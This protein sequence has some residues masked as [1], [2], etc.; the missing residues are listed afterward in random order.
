MNDVSFGIYESEIHAIVGENG[1]G[2][3]TLMNILS[4]LLMA[5]SGTIAYDGAESVAINSPSDAKKLGIATV[6]QELK[7]C[8]ELTVAENI[9]L[10]NELR[11]RFGSIEW[12]KMRDGTRE[13]LESYGLDIDPNEVVNNLSVAKMQMIEIA[14]AIDSGLKVIIFD[15]PTSSLTLN[16]AKKFFD[17]IRELQKKGVTII[18]I[19]HRIEEVFDISD[20]ISVL[21]DGK[22]LC[23]LEKDKASPDEVVALIAGKSIE[24]IRRRVHS[25][26]EVSKEVI[27]DVENLSRGKFFQNVSFQL[28]KEEIL[29]VYG[30]QGSG[31]S[32]LMET[33]FGIYKPT[34]GTITLD[35]KRVKFNRPKDAMNEGLAF[36]PED[37][38]RVGVFIQMSILDNMAVVHDKNIKSK[39]GTISIKKIAELCDTYIKKLGIKAET[40]YQSLGSLSGGNQQKVVIGR[41]LSVNPSVLLLDEPTRGVDVGAKAEIF[42]ILHALRKDEGKSILMISSELNEVIEECDRVVVMHNGRMCA[43]LS[44]DELTKNNILNYAFNG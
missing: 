33:L 4:G 7:L 15:E 18:F 44:G 38:K 6:F 2:K 16:E 22:Y 12:D 10:G 26:K 17:N 21:R 3:S 27:L 8:P 1:A 5:D 31:R 39:I 40:I 9:Y 23:T 28:H 14:R 13:M 34:E 42:R 19:S 25:S 32:E 30:L 20:R 43:S 24:E 11:N 35:G 29:G 36:V 41:G 37:R